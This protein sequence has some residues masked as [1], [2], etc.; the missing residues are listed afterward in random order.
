MATVDIPVMLT[1]LAAIKSESIYR[2]GPVVHRGSIRTKE[3]MNM[4]TK[5]LA[6][7][8]SEGFVR[9]LSIRIVP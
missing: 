3:P 5:K 8:I 1:A 4:N 7:S 9:R 6:D 2:R